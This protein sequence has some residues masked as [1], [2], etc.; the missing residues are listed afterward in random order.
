MALN[1]NDFGATQ[2]A[3]K[4]ST[5]QVSIGDFQFTAGNLKS[6]LEKDTGETL[7]FT[8]KEA[9]GY[10]D[11]HDSDEA[12]RSAEQIRLERQRLEDKEAREHAEEVRLEE[13][14]RLGDLRDAA[15][16]DVATMQDIVSGGGEPEP[17]FKELG[18]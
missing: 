15:Q 17:M 9:Q 7:P 11:V 6:A 16:R 2:F 3:I 10:L 5:A 18:L 13:L 4:S 8:Q 1:M 14:T 12:R